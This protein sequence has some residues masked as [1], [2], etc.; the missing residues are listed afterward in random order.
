VK[1][2]NTTLERIEQAFA[3]A[4]AAGDHEAAEGWIATA[5]FVSARQTDRRPARKPAPALRLR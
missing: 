4:V 3:E 2:R 1:L 5:V